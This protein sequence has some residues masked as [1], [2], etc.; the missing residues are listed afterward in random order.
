MTKTHQYTGFNNPQSWVISRIVQEQAKKHPKRTAIRFINGPEWTFAKLRTEALQTA[1]W[2]QQQGVN[3]G[4]RVALMCDDPVTFCRCWLG[5]A[6]LGATM[7]AINTSVRGEPLRH[8]LALAEV[9]HVIADPEHLTTVKACSDKAQVFSSSELTNNTANTLEESAVHPAKHSDLSCI[10]FTSGTS[11]PSKG[12]LMPEAHCVLFAVG[13]IENLRLWGKHTYYICLPLFHANGLHMQLL[14]CLVSGACAVIRARFSA[15]NWLSDIRIYGATH[16]NMLG[17]LSAFVVAQPISELDGEHQLQVIS[18]APL[19]AATDQALRER[20]KVPRVVPLYGMTEVNIPLYGTFDEHAPGT[21]GRVYERYFA[22]EIRDPET[23]EP[24]ATGE[25]GE[26][27]VRPKQPWGFMSGYVGMPEKTLEAWRNFWF[28]TGDAA[29]LD[30]EG[31]FVF[32]DRIKDCIRRRGENISSYEVEQAFLALDGIAEAAAYAVP[33][34]AEG[35]ED[36]VMVALEV[37]AGTKVDIQSWVEQ[38][39]KNLAAFAVPR[40]VRIVEA[41]PKTPTGK[42]RKVVLR[43][44]GITEDTTETRLTHKRA[45]P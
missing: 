17:A 3:T 30:A 23:D 35:M 4:T 2:L 15:S 28:H 29:R 37:Q 7:V 41:L 5:L 12:V 13:T 36:E 8:Q 26:I 14:A 24:V 19:P 6:M 10:M 9:S 1:G 32:V 33:A 21:C 44:E 31:R 39:A 25:T 34:G 18:S 38:A 20:F 40:F 42:I 45:A 16:T 11:G 43:N 22:V 27:M